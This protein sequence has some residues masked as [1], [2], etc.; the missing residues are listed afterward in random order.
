M[1]FA[2]FDGVPMVF[3]LSE[4]GSVMAVYDVTDPA[5]PVLAQLLPSGI[6]PEGAVAIPSRGLVA[7]ANEVDLG[8]D[9]AARAHV[10]VYERQAGAPAYPTLTS[11]GAETLVGWGAIS[12]A[13]ADPEV[14]GRLWAVSDS[15]Y[16]MAPAIYQIDAS[17]TPARILAAIPVTRL[18]QPA[19][20]IDLEGI[21]TDGAGGFWLASEGRSDRLVPHALYRVDARGRIT[22]EVAI[23]AELSAQE[24]RFGFEGIARVGDVLWMAVQREWRDDPKGHVK[25][26]SYD[27]KARTW[28]AVHYPLETPAEGAWMGLSEITVHGDWAYIVER[29]NQ[30]GDAAQVK[31]VY[32]VALASLVPAPLGGPLPVVEKELVRDLV[33]DLARWGGYIQ[34]KVES[35]AIDAAGTAYVITDNDG[36]AD[37]S[38]ETHFWTFGPVE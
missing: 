34:D 11:E 6:S 2:V 22:A 36:V 21:T 12:G 8:E 26:V 27:A 10:M 1:E 15:V 16:S 29:D 32:R 13:V 38:G 25:L 4:R 18:G 5:A 28:G 17:Q 37:A 35:L 9:G 23:P 7:T 30:I 24:I 33:P 20:L 31:R 14:P 3:V 19:Q